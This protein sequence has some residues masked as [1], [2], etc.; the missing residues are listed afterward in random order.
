MKKH[1]TSCLIIFALMCQFSILYAA[2]QQQPT[3]AGKLLTQFSNGLEEITPA[4]QTDSAEIINNAA[5]E[6]NP[7]QSL[8]DAE[9][10]VSGYE[11]LDAGPVDVN[12]LQVLAKPYCG[13]NIHSA[14]L[15]RL[16]E[17]IAAHY[18][19][20]GYIF[21]QAYLPS[22]KSA[23][24]LIKIRI[25]VGKY[26]NIYLAKNNSNVDDAII[27]MEL[28]AVKPGDYI[29]WST[30]KR[31]VLLANDLKRVAIQAVFEPGSKTGTANLVIEAEPLGDKFTETLSLDNAGNYYTSSWGTLQ[32]SSISQFNNSFGRGDQLNLA[33]S[34]AGPNMYNGALSWNTP[35][36]TA[37]GKASAGVAGVNYTLGRQYQSQNIYG[38]AEIAFLGYDYSIIRSKTNN[39][40]IAARFEGRYLTDINNS[41]TQNRK[42]GD[43]VV[44][45]SGD[46]FDQ[47]LGGS[48]NSY[49][50]SVQPGYLAAAG[51]QSQNMADTGQLGW[52]GLAQ[53]SA[54]RYQSLFANTTLILKANGQV[55]NTN[56]NSSAEFSL[57]GID[58]VR[59]YPQGD[60]SGDEGF[61]AT[62]EL[63]YSIPNF[64]KSI[65]T[66]GVQLAGF[67]DAGYIQFN[68]DISKI[69]NWIGPNT[70]WLSGAGVGLIYA[71]VSNLSGRVDIAWR[72]SP[73]APDDG[74][75]NNYQLWLRLTST[76]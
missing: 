56:L 53:A 17:I 67:F 71:P 36:F 35:L 33:I 4:G 58:A 39:L 23:D 59:A 7:A 70:E 74:S 54:V 16:L 31:A 61:T 21:A 6:K 1:L 27:M 43:L 44:T 19:E 29:N 68:K 15:N 42:V 40:N 25:I 57:G 55:A 50:L 24:G 48:Y 49:S 63:R 73:A 22:Q 51:P 11:F 46:A 41:G 64:T 47:L 5:P 10:K 32:L 72:T 13:R 30:L 20:A 60:D 12:E 3:D 76:F 52:Y 45:L 75:T 62:A 8:A 37:G 2:T 69:Q 14:E 26:D 66:S 28:G 38:N 65:W 34:V 18:R 9:F